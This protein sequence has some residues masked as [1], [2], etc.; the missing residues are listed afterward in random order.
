MQADLKKSLEDLQPYEIV[1]KDT[2][3]KHNKK[4]KD[5]HNEM[6]KVDGEVSHVSDRTDNVNTH[7]KTINAKIIKL[8]QKVATFNNNNKTAVDYIED[9]QK[10]LQALRDEAVA[11]M[12]VM[13]KRVDEYNA[14]RTQLHKEVDQINSL[15]KNKDLKLQYHKDKDTEITDQGDKLINLALKLKEGQK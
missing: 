14:K 12:E 15:I 9:K 11:E 10:E 1:F 8:Q 2:I 4:R 3:A 6:A 13:T 7:V 5:L